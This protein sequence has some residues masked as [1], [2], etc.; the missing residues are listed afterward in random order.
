M[1]EKIRTIAE[2]SESLKKF[3]LRFAGAG[4][5]NV[6]FETDA[7]ERKL[8]KI[9]AEDFRTQIKKFLAHEEGASVLDTQREKMY[10]LKRQQRDIVDS[11]GKE[12][13]L[14][15]GF[16]KFKVPL[17]KSEVI[18]ILDEKDKHLAESLKDGEEY[19]IETILRTQ[20]IAEEIRNKEKYKT[21]EVRI[22]L[23]TQNDFEAG[24]SID[25]S[26]EKVRSNMDLFF[27][28]RAGKLISEDRY[29]QTYKEII[30][31]I[32]SFTKKTGKMIDIF[33]RDNITI[34]EKEDGSIDY[35][36]VDPILPGREK[37][38]NVN[39]K[40]DKKREG[41]R[42]HYSYY[43]GLKKAAEILGIDEQIELG[44]LSYFKNMD[45]ELSAIIR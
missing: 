14:E 29:K 5:E 37:F 8:V 1:K 15:S 39:I 41:L 17:K 33:G 27:S 7:S 10:E 9:A 35:H 2:S 13:V 34:F 4:A 12:H 23:I 21:R 38:W 6:T 42:H 28:E 22:T 40:D 45:K 31:R 24:G 19:K 43:Y 26:L 36:L 30:S 11:F 32:V 20:P 25:D 18:E 3:N 16:F 44:D